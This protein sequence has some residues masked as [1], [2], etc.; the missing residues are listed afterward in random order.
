MAGLLFTPPLIIPLHHNTPCPIHTWTRRL[1]LF[2]NSRNAFRCLLKSCVSHSTRTVRSGA[3]GNHREPQGRVPVSSRDSWM[4][5]YAVPLPCGCHERQVPW[6]FHEFADTQ[7]EGEGNHHPT[8]HP[9]EVFPQT[10]GHSCQAACQGS[11]TGARIHRALCLPCGHN[12]FQNL[13]CDRLQNLV[14]L[15]ELQESRQT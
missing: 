7:A 8:S 14:R 11:R 2:P 12:Q 6:T 13:G 5:R 10:L 15:Q 4:Q 3:C 1:L 9:R